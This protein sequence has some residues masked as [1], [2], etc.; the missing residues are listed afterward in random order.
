MLNEDIDDKVRQPRMHDDDLEENLEIASNKE[1]EIDTDNFTLTEEDELAVSVVR[2]VAR[3]L[4][5]HPTITPKDVVALGKALYALE[6]MPLS[7]PKVCCSFGVYF[8]Y[9]DDDRDF[10]EYIDFTISDSTC[11]IHRG[12]IS[13][14]RGAGS[15]TSSNIVWSIEV[16]IDMRGETSG[17]N[18]I[19][20]D[21]SEY[22]ASD[23]KIEISDMSK[24]EFHMDEEEIKTDPLT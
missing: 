21:V 18:E 12:E 5:N 2:K 7:T 11:E 15:D 13:S 10:T 4:L 16:G 3:R 6:R 20:D 24:N 22:L 8:R 9:G 19:L 1:E 23:C 17:L 14:L